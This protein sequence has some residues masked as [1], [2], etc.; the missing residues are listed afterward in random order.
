MAFYTY[1]NDIQPVFLCIA[2]MVMILFC[3]CRAVMTLKDIRS[4]QFASSNGIINSTNSFSLLGMPNKK[5]FI[6]FSKCFFT[7]LCLAITK[8]G[9]LTN[10]FTLF[11]LSVASLSGLA[12]LALLIMFFCSLSFFCFVVFFGVL[13]PANFAITSEPAFTIW[14]FVKFRKQFDLFAFATSFRYDFGSHFR[15]L[16][17][18]LWSESIARPSCG[19]L[20][21]F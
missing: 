5:S 21:L 11:A 9:L 10:S 20:V 6:T 16:Y 13:R 8:P 4:R 15:L 18:R 3:L 14:T 19:R 1:R 7:F 17:R 2:F 12:L